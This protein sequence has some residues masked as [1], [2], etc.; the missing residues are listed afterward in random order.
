MIPIMT[1][2]IVLLLG[3][4][5]EGKGVITCVEV[6]TA[7]IMVAI[8]IGVFVE[9]AVRAAVGVSV[10]AAIGCTTSLLINNLFPG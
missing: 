6:N 1:P 4:G 10:G 8:G 5:D 3:G 2:M 7:R 9:I